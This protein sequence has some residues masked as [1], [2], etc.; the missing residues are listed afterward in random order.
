[1]SFGET[2]RPVCLPS[3]SQEYEQ[4]EVVVTGWGRQFSS[5][6]SSDLLHRAGVRSLTNSQCT[7]GTLYQPGQI[8]DNMICAA[9]SGKV[10]HSILYPRL[11][12][13]FTDLMHGQDS[14]QGD[15]GGPLVSPEGGGR[16]YSQ[17]GVVS[18]GYGCALPNAPG[19]YS[20]VTA[21]LDWI[22]SVETSWGG[23][24]CPHP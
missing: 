23:D 6:P 18:W 13:N 2:I 10:L 19:V 24:N 9:A 22:N 1:M 7:T 20:R 14:C 11:R 4:R 8:T 12:Q 3:A 21:A 15:S 5:G 16:Y 17:V